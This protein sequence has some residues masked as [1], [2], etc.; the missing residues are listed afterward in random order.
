[1]MRRLRQIIYALTSIGAVSTLA[2]I[3]YAGRSFHSLVSGFTPWALT[4]YAVF[5]LA[6]V[7]VRLRW[8]AVVVLASSLVATIYAAAAYA[9]AFFIHVHSTSAIIFIFLPFYQLI[10]AA[11]VLL[12]SLVS[13]FVRPIPTI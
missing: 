10:L 12:L 6:G 9:D 11:T 7:A 8:V 13:R 3:A 1:M 4:P 5:A 2:F